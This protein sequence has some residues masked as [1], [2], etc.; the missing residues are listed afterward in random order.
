VKFG[1]VE[2]VSL[3]AFLGQSHFGSA[4][5]LLSIHAVPLPVCWGFKLGFELANAI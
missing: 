5:F 2:V 1:A 4:F 3:N